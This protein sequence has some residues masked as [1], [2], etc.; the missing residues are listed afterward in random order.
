MTTITAR[1]AKWGTVAWAALAGLGGIALAAFVFWLRD[2]QRGSAIADS[3]IE[4]AADRW[5]EAQAKYDVA[6]AIIK[7]KDQAAKQELREIKREPEW[8]TR[9]ERMRELKERVMGEKS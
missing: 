9:M 1:L 7:A 8:R 3:A 6:M 5:N 4:K 2:K